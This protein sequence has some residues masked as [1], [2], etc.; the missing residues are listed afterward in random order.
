MRDFRITC[1]N[2]DDGTTEYRDYRTSS[3]GEALAMAERDDAG[4]QTLTYGI[5]PE[6]YDGARAEGIA[7]N[8]AD[9]LLVDDAPT[10]TNKE[11]E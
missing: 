1:A 4:R 11:Q 10:T 3:I 7:F 9:G 8:E 2:D 5:Q 6:D